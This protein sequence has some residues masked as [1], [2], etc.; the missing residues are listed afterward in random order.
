MV[1][2]GTSCWMIRSVVVGG[3]VNVADIVGLVK[4]SAEVDVEVS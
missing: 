2:C 3:I 1:D 4:V